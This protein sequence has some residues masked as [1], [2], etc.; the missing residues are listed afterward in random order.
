MV[1]FHL[2][3]LG[4]YGFIHGLLAGTRLGVSAMAGFPSMYT[5]P[6][7]SNIAVHGVNVFSMDSK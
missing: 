5:I 6:H 2:P 1:T 7:T 3:V 4:E